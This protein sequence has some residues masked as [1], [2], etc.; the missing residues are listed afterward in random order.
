MKRVLTALIL[1]PLVIALVLWA[2]APLFLAALGL[3]ALLCFHEY[4]ALVARHGIE[5]P[6]P[7]GYAAGLLLFLV[8]RDSVLVVTLLALL[9]LGLALGARPLEKALPRA[10]AFVLG[11]VYIFGAWR[12]AA[13]LRAID[14]YW[15]LF[16]LALNWAGDTAAYYVGRWRGRHKLA[17]AVSPAKSW[18][19]A[20]AS[21]AASL[22]FA[23]LYCRALLPEVPVQHALL[24]AGA[25]NL[26]GQIG[27]LAE[28]ALKRGAG[29]KDS[30]HLLPGHGGWLDRTDSSLFAAPVVYALV[31]ALRSAG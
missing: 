19:G 14:P 7:A 5:R 24:L 21:V 20:I 22:L 11:I 29:V 10:A 18:E 12:C 2:P 4:S 31:M 17:P 26:A 16:G 1:A 8:P 15:L 6:G 23:V 30:G 3:V 28:S 9:A 25:G 27:D 13:A